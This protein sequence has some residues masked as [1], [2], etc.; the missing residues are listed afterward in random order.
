MEDWCEVDDEY[1][2]IELLDVISI[3]L[4]LLIVLIISKVL[5][6][7]R[8][9]KQNGKLPWIVKKLWA[10]LLTFPSFRRE[11]SY[12]RILPGGFS[13]ALKHWE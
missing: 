3:L 7:Y 5:Y 11:W 10:F 6:D 4:A 13:S 8:N 2:M 12:V 9:Y 1:G